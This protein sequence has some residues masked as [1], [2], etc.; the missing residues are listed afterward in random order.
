MFSLNSALALEYNDTD[1]WCCQHNFYVIRNGLH[2]YQCNCSQITT[3]KTHRCHQ[4]QTDPNIAFVC[5]L[6][7]Y[8]KPCSHLTSAF[9]FTSNF[10]NGFCGNKWWCSYWTFAFDGKDQ[11]KNSYADVKFEKGLTRAEYPILKQV[12]LNQENL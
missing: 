5:S 9:A 8:A 10:K 6:F 1:F 11:K 3:E 4:V 7:L 2:G 12:N